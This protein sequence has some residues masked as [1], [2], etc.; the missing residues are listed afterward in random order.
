MS[1]LL[2]A[3]YS[4]STLSTSSRPQPLINP[5]NL[6]LCWWSKLCYAGEWENVFHRP[7]RSRRGVRREKI[8][9]LFCWPQRNRLRIPQG[10]EARKEKIYSVMAGRII[11]VYIR[12]R[13]LIKGPYCRKACCYLFSFFS[14]ENK[15]KNRLCVLRDSEVRIVLSKTLLGLLSSHPF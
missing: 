3:A 2:L 9:F 8:C 12:T 14:K 4:Y 15:S 13:F 1:F 10:R 5:L 11:A 6:Q 7:L